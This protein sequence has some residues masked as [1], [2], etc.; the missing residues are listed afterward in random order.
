M[1]A[2]YEWRSGTWELFPRG[3]A[4]TQAW[5]DRMFAQAVLLGKALRDDDSEAYTALCGDVR[6]LSNKRSKVAWTN[7]EAGVQGQ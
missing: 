6:Y 5:Y 1:I 4:A 3:A 7:Q 2:I